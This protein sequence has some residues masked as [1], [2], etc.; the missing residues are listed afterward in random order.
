M[1]QL[2]EVFVNVV[3]E[4]DERIENE[5]QHAEGEFLRVVVKQKMH[6]GANGQQTNV[7]LREV[8]EQGE[9]RVALAK[10]QARF[11]LVTG[12]RTDNEQT[13]AGHHHHSKHDRFAS[14][15][16]AHHS[17]DD[18]KGRVEHPERSP[19]VPFALVRWREDRAQVEPLLPVEKDEQ[20]QR[21]TESDD[22]ANDGPQVSRRL[23]RGLLD[24]NGVGVINARQEEHDHEDLCEG[25]AD[26]R[27][28]R[29]F[30]DRLSVR[31]KF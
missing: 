23:L 14:V 17:L 1:A 22:Y 28:E 11:A 20:E 21:Q 25:E 16:F 29:G 19:Q 26:R 18:A 15:D 8:L 31:R 10:G 13:L 3:E 27:G 2:T 12:Q 9:V 24:E 7:E 4:F 6:P 5:Q 30:T